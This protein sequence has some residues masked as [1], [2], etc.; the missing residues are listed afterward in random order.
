MG[1]REDDVSVC[2]VQEAVSKVL[3]S[4]NDEFIM[5]IDVGMVNFVSDRDGFMLLIRP[6][7]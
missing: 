7:G 6:E 1:A 5:H 2:M 3:V 4:K